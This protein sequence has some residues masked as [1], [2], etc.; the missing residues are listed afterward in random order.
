M[1]KLILSEF[2]IILRQL[3]YTKLKNKDTITDLYA[4]NVI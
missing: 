1:S 4:I 3:S 2:D